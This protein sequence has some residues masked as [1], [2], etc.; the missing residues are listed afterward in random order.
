MHVLETSP[1]Q[2]DRG[3]ELVRDQLLPWLR[4]STGFRGLIRLA[5]LDRTK[6]IVI[7]LWVDEDAL[8]A[9]AEAGDKLSELTAQT[10]GVTRL[11]L[12]EMEVSL[13]DVAGV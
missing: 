11:A 5:D 2:H 6:S 7:T 9:S 10:V 8:R 13:F 1:A 12:E 4:E 3:L